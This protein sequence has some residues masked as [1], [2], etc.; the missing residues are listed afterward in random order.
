MTAR[1]GLLTIPAS[2]DATS[3]NLGAVADD[4]AVSLSVDAEGRLRVLV[5]PDHLGT[6]QTVPVVAG[7]V[8]NS[9][10]ATGRVVGPAAGQTIATI[11]AAALPSG[12][13]DVQVTVVLDG[14]VAAAE[15]NNVQ[16]LRGATVVTALA[17]SAAAGVV[18]QRVV[19]VILDGATA[20]SVQ[21]IAAGTAGVGYT[22]ELVA[23]QVA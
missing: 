18:T 16:F 3:P 15:I 7:L 13:Y 8:K 17:T 19:R 1:G 10:G 11:P 9:V 4:S 6:P 21:A 12:T 2:K 23:T 22:A 20:V 5:A 14:A